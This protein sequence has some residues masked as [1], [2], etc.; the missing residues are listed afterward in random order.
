MKFLISMLLGL[1]LGTAA[2]FLKPDKK[3]RRNKK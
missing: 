1:L 2:I 3:K